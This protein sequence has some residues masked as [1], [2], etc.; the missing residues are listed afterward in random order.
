MF[1]SECHGLLT[2]SGM[3]SR[4]QFNAAAGIETFDI[5][6]VFTKSLDTRFYCPTNIL[7]LL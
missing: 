7:T 5:K 1:S 3:F 4:V 2:T 6:W